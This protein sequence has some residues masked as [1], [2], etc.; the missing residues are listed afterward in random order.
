LHRDSSGRGRKER[1]PTEKSPGLAAGLSLIFGGLGQF[2]AGAPVR[3]VFWLA[4]DA[5]SALLI[6]TSMRATAGSFQINWGYV[7]FSLIVT[8]VSM[9]DAYMAAVSYNK[10]HVVACPNCGAKSLRSAPV[11]LLCGMQLRAPAP[12]PGQ[13]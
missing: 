12:V 4:L 8:I 6:F 7:A 2:Y 11:C 10:R 5:F 1:V 13:T 3:G 9:V